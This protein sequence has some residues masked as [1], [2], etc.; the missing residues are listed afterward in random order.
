MHQMAC[1]CH[2]FDGFD[3]V[4]KY[5]LQCHLIRAIPDKDITL[6]HEILKVLDDDGLKELLEITQMYYHVES[7][8]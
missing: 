8:A 7:S 3:T 5:K 6:W 1:Q 4:I 2:V